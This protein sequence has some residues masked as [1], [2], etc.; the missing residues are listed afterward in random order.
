MTKS[1]LDDEIREQPEVLRNLLQVEKDNIQKIADDLRGKFKYIVIAARGTSDNAARYAQYLFGAHNHIQVAL[2]TPSLFSVYNSPPDLSEALVICISQSG[3][4]PDIVSVITEGHRQGRPTLAITNDCYS[5]LAKNADH[6]IFL[7][8]KEEKAVAAT[9]TYT[10]SLMSLALFSCFLGNHTNWLTQLERVPDAVKQ[11]ILSIQNNI[12]HVERY[13]YVEHCVVIGRGFNYPTA[14][15][16]ALKIKEL[17]HVVAVP[18]S[19]ADF[20]HGPIATVHRGFPVVVIAPSGELMMDMLEFINY[21]KQLGAELIVI[22]DNDQ[23]LETAQLPFRIPAGLPEWIS[24]IAAILPGQFFS[25]KLAI[26]R[27]L[28]PDKPEGITKITE[29]L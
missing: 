18:Y 29:T 20:K 5:P 3:Q 21:L 6:I 27:N 11:T 1:I 8:C 15:E 2:A 9:K 12:Q 23:V 28:D 22:S 19:S 14:F 25:M 26:E 16:I 7:N 13:R 10:S 4:S 24:P 17:T